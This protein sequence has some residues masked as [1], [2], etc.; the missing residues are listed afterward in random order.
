MC[1][2]LPFAKLLTKLLT[3]QKQVRN[4]SGVVKGNVKA[5]FLGIIKEE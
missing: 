1:Q 4:Y 3:T 5:K 2:A